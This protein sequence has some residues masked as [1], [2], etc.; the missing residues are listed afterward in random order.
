[1]EPRSTSVVA[2]DRGTKFVAALDRQKV[3]DVAESTCAAG[4]SILRRW[5]E[6]EGVVG[7]LIAKVKDYVDRGARQPDGSYVAV[8]GR[9]STMLLATV[10]NVVDKLTKAAQAM[11][12]VSDAQARLYILLSGGVEKRR[13]AETMSEKQLMEVLVEGMKVIKAK[14]GKCPLCDSAPVIDVEAVSV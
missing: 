1:V 11:F 3:V 12:R 2:L 6:L 8:E 13:S 9:E 5:S 7:S 4:E 10:A 14:T